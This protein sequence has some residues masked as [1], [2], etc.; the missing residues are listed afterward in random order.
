MPVYTFLFTDIEGST[1]LWEQRP[2]AMRAALTRHHA[3]LHAAIAAHG[4]EVFQI[5]GDGFCAVFARPLPALLAALDAQRALLAEFGGLIDLPIKVRIACT[6]AR[7]SPPP[8]TGLTLN[9]LSRVLAAGHGSQ[10]LLAASTVD[11]LPVPLPPGVRVR[12]LGLRRLRDVPQPERLY[13]LVAPGLPEVFAPLKTL[14]ARSSNLPAP[15]TSFVGR[16]AELDAVPAIAARTCA[17]SRWPGRRHRQDAPG[18]SPRPR[19]CTTNSTTARVSSRWPTCAIPRCRRR[20]DAGAGPGDGRPPPAVLREE[21][22]ERDAA[23][24][25]QFEQ[26][27]PPAAITDLLAHAPAVRRWVGAM[28]CI[29]GSTVRRA[30]LAQPRRGRLPL[31]VSA[32]PAVALRARRVAAGFGSAQNA[33]AA[34][35]LRAPGR[36]AA[37]DRVGGGAG[38]GVQPGGPV[39]PAGA[40]RAR[41]GPP[42]RP[43][44]RDLPARRGLHGAIEWSYDLLRPSTRTSYEVP[45]GFD[46]EGPRPSPAQTCRPSCRPA[47][48]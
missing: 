17:C 19:P 28:P 42:L 26:S 4:G 43:R 9:R 48:R 7:P 33:A 25:R 30:A 10:V 16:E 21:L 15:L 18:A 24:A 1:R 39:G 44:P 46:E 37:G 5:V 47:T 3:L 22:A 13:Q 2:E 11:A 31:E 23:R 35:D 34:R 32:H 45:G 38:E 14:D 20:A 40:G 27:S 12:D 36:P 41:P 6:A 29:Y 8:A